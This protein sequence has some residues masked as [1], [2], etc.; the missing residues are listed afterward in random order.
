[1]KSKEVYDSMSRETRR[2]NIK[3]VE[4]LEFVDLPSSLCRSSTT[5]RT[6]DR[7]KL[8]GTHQSNAPRARRQA[9]KTVKSMLYHFNSLPKY[10]YYSKSFLKE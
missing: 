10:F 1:M 2:A 8:R 7:P 5:L 6:E 3:R 4:I 9:E